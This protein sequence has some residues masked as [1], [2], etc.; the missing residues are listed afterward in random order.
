YDESAR[1]RGRAATPEELCLV[2]TPEYVAAI[3]RL[4][5]PE[6]ALTSEE[7]RKERAQLAFH[8]GFD[9]TDTPVLPRMHEVSACIAGG[10]LVALR[11]V[12]GLPEGGSSGLPGS[13]ASPDSSAGSVKKK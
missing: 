9:D 3:Q 6:G 5:I 11:T 8:Y 4:S 10:T 12:M 2:H 13:E 7:E 1:L